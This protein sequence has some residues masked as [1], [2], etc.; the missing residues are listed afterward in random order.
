MLLESYSVIRN[1]T[2]ISQHK[3][4]VF[5]PMY[6]GL[7]LSIGTLHEHTSVHGHRHYHSEVNTLALQGCISVQLH[8][9]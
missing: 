9:L 7:F 6:V 1:L 3:R 4:I 8:E 2:F 5:V